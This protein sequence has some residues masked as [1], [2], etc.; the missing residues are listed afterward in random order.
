MAG[1]ENFLSPGFSDTD[2]YNIF[3]NCT[4]RLVSY[5]QDFRKGIE[6]GLFEKLEV[7]DC[8]K[9]YTQQYVSRRGDLL[10][11]QKST[12]YPDY[13]RLVSQSYNQ[14]CALAQWWDPS[15]NEFNDKPFPFMVD[16]HN[17]PSYDW[18][19]PWPGIQYGCN[20]T[21]LT[22]SIDAF[23]PW[24]PF[25]DPVEY[26]WSER[27]D[28]ECTLTFNT[29]ICIAVIAFNL[30]KASCMCLTL[31]LTKSSALMTLGDAIESFMHRP[32]QHT[33]GMSTFSA[34]RLNL[35]WEQEKIA[36]AL[37]SF[38]G[39]SRRRKALEKFFS[40]TWSPTR[41]RWWRAATPSRF[42]CFVL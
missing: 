29:P 28:E 41:P 20:A 37:P 10:V 2:F 26:C 34:D 11:I 14:S 19:C 6:S 8:R 35:F 4:T 39:G 32:D 15:I 12:E 21:T 9:E 27:L 1:P 24:E 30:I 18:Q 38:F 5:A 13:N 33:A 40:Q 23:D 36:I 31:L 3:D 17:V 22:N 7:E 25:G 42:H 16:P